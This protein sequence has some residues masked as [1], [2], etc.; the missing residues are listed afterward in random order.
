MLFLKKEETS[1]TIPLTSKEFD[2]QKKE[3]N[4]TRIQKE[5]TG[6]LWNSTLPLPETAVPAFQ[7]L[8]YNL[9]G[10]TKNLELHRK[11]QL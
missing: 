6:K 2:C 3:N 10:Y 7:I 11:I 1:S 5:C 4:Q 9:K 8:S